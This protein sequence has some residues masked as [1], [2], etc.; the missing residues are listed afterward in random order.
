MRPSIA[1]I[2]EQLDPRLQL[3][4]IPPPQSATLGL[5]PVAGN[6]LLISRPD[7]GRET[8]YIDNAF[9]MV[10]EKRARDTERLETHHE[11]IQHEL[12]K[13]KCAYLGL[14]SNYAKLQNT[15][16]VALLSTELQYHSSS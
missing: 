1:R 6:L 5:H 12:L 8:A 3:A 15:L 13:R 16:G 11:K 4:D 9:K 10:M 2:N 14:S 7:E